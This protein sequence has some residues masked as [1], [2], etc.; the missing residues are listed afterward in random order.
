MSQNG[1]SVPA[2]PS[3]YRQRTGTR[4]GSGGSGGGKR[5]RRASDRTSFETTE[6]IET[7]SLFCF[8]KSRTTEMNSDAKREQRCSTHV[9]RRHKSFDLLEQSTR[10][11]RCKNAHDR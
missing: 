2:K 5:K 6:M 1:D 8:E 9:C 4:G 11:V 3:P 7:L 10:V